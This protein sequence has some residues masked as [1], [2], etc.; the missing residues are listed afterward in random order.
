[1]LPSAPRGVPPVRPPL[2]SNGGR[3][4][5]SNRNMRSRGRGPGNQGGP[6]GQGGP[7]AHGP[8]PLLGSDFGGRDG[9]GFR[10][11]GPRP[12][13]AASDDFRGPPD[14]WEA[15]P[16]RWGGPRGPPGRWDDDWNGPPGGNRW[17]SSE[18]WER[19]SRSSRERRRETKPPPLMGPD[20]SPFYSFNFG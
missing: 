16:D 3:G 19:G 14:R 8:R 17:G 15:P 18:R 1:M 2:P 4:G 9:P 20:V 10:P 6:R 13:M 5:P 12:L 11:R 7:R